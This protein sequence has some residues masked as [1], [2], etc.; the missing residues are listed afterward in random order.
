MALATEEVE[1]SYYFARF[2]QRTYVRK[3]N[4]LCTLMQLRIHIN[5]GSGLHVRTIVQTAPKGALTEPVLFSLS[6]ATVSRGSVRFE[7]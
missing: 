2:F 6:Y 3:M 5:T 1:V 7:R 4:G